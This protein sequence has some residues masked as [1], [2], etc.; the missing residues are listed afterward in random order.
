V[1][2]PGDGMGKEPVTNDAIARFTHDLRRLGAANA[3]TAGV[4]SVLF[5]QAFPVE[6]RHN[7]TLSRDTLTL[8][9][10]ERLR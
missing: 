1:P 3:L 5:Y 10:A 7:E 8:G 4:T 2:F 6:V 9:V